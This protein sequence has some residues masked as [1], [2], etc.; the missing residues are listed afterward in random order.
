MISACVI[1]SSYCWTSG[2]EQVVSVTSLVRGLL[3]EP[4]S[5][6]LPGLFAKEILFSCYTK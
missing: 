1:S 6:L 2:G 4:A 3:L 5:P